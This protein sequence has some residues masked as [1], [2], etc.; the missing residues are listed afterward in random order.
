M[1][2][3]R[4]TK[5]LGALLITLAL[6]V[7]VAPAADAHSRPRGPMYVLKHKCGVTR[8]VHEWSNEIPLADGTV[9]VFTHYVKKRKKCRTGSVITIVGT[10]TSF[11]PAPPPVEG[12]PVP[13]A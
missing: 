5:T 4:V 8:T 11:I 6:V 9:L 7:G 2:T 3:A 13:A 1:H 10:S 12:T